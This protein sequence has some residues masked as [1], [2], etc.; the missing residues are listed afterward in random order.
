MPTST[1]RS[2]SGLIGLG[3]ATPLLASEC[4]VANRALPLWVMSTIEGEAN[5]PKF[6]K[7]DPKQVI[8]GRGRAAQQR[9][10]PYRDALR[11]NAAGRV[12]LDQGDD[13]AQVKRDLRTAARELG[14]RIR[15]SWED[16]RQRA[17]LWKRTGT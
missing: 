13:P 6:Q 15:S 5:M 10:A 11:A 1:H 14:L 4:L 16:D 9:R 2:C 17:L 8:L 3:Y 12:E 7:L